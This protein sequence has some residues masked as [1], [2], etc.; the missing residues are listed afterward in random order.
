MEDKETSLGYMFDNK[1]EL[2]ITYDG[3]FSYY[4]RHLK[5]WYLPKPLCVWSGGITPLLNTL[6]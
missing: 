2:A 5:K 3:G 4:P 1:L 6:I